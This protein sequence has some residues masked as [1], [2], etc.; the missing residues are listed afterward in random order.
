MYERGL[1]VAK[2]D[3]RGLPGIA[4]REKGD[5]TGMRDLGGMYLRGR[6]VTRDVAQRSSGFRKALRRVCLG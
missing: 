4:T 6:G 5:P 2:D 3:A 1:G